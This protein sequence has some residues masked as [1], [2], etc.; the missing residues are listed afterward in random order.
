MAAMPSS[1]SSVGL[2]RWLLALLNYAIG[3]TAQATGRAAHVLDWALAM[4][5]SLLVPLAYGACPQG[6]S[7]PS[8]LTWGEGSY[9]RPRIGQVPTYP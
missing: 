8:S 3:V 1:A 6:T 5:T 9:A 7:A 4:L 2:L